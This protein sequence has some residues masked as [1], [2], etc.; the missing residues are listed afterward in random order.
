M[1]K[2]DALIFLYDRRYKFLFSSSPYGL[3]LSRL[4]ATDGM[5]SPLFLGGADQSPKMEELLGFDPM[6]ANVW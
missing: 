3:M 1:P 5:F 6:S 4:S 2:G